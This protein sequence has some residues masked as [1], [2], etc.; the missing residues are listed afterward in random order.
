MA[1]GDIGAAVIDTLIL[2]T[3][4]LTPSTV[5][6]KSDKNIFATAYTYTNGDGKVKTY[7][8]D[9]SG[10]ISAAIDTLEFDTSDGDSPVIIKAHDGIFA[11]AYRGPDGDGFCKTFAISDTGTIG[12]V[13]DTLEFDTSDC[14]PRQ[15][16]FLHISG[17]VFAFAYQGPLIHVVVKTWSISNS[18]TL[19]SVIDTL[20]ISEAQ[21]HG[22]DFEHL[23]GN[24][25][26]LLF[27]QLVDDTKLYTF[28]I[29]NAGSI[30]AVIDSTS[31]D[32]TGS[33]AQKPAIIEVASNI[34][35]LAY[36]ASSGSAVFETRSIAADGTIGAQVDISDVAGPPDDIHSIGDNVYAYVYAA[37]GNCFAKTRTISSA[38]AI[39]SEVDTLTVA[40]SSS[41]YPMLVW[42]TGHI[43]VC[44]LTGPATSDGLV[45]TFTIE[46]AA[47]LPS[48]GLSRVTAIRHI[49]RPG[50]YRLEATLGDLS[51]SVELAQ[52]YSQPSRLEPAKEEPVKEPK[53][54]P[55]PD[56][57]T[58][59]PKDKNLTLF[60]SAPG[61]WMS[62]RTAEELQR[63]LDRQR[64]LDIWRE[65]ENA[66]RLELAQSQN[67]WRRIT[68]W[69]EEL[70]ETFGSEV[71][72][73]IQ[74]VTGWFRNLFGIGEDNG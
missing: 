56:E 43:F 15:G 24:L 13:I 11:V 63:E 25:Y 29:T 50:S 66:Q 12:S 21:N 52:R 46:R 72:E 5:K 17:D 4:G 71:A 58:P 62:R 30:S 47:P 1:T 27:Q 23:T 74:A 69:R 22:I 41:N 73:R 34:Y 35:L 14:R 10:N 33:S 64:Q 32:T 8:V 40:L 18:G 44:S 3:T 19:G 60:P 45:K 68:P 51:T 36:V 37:G 54:M 55:I 61:V 42:H 6:V 26:A 9:S 53:E 20:D 65:Q 49:Y 28:N 59:T 16:N 39:G 70:G 57:P 7:S 67:L 38:G 48:W 2:E 31:L